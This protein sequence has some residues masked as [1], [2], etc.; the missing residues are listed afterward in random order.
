[1][2]AK[3]K[4]DLPKGVKDVLPDKAQGIYRK[5]YNKAYDEYTDKSKRRGSES[6]EETASKVA[7]SAVKGKYQKGDDGRWHPKKK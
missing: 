3:T 6:Q 2:P 1:M 4:K 7:W 5:A